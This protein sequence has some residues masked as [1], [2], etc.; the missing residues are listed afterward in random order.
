MA[1]LITFFC[2]CNPAKNGIFLFNLM[3]LFMNTELFI[4]KEEA[5][6]GLANLV[7]RPDQF[8]SKTGLIESIGQMSQREIFALVRRAMDEKSIRAFDSAKKP[9]MGLKPAEDPM[10][11]AVGSQLAQIAGELKR[12]FS[13]QIAERKNVN[14]IKGAA[15]EKGKVLFSDGTV[16]SEKELAKDPFAR[17]LAGNEMHLRLIDED[18]ANLAI[19]EVM[20]LMR[21]DIHAAIYREFDADDEEDT[22]VHHDAAVVYAF[23][24][25]NAQSKNL[26]RA[27]RE[28]HYEE[29]RLDMMQDS[30][31]SKRLVVRA[32]PFMTGKSGFPLAMMAEFD[33]RNRA[34]MLYFSAEEKEAIKPRPVRPVGGGERTQYGPDP[35]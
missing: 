27:F 17:A 11:L 1:G 34:H 15:V 14:R 9:G 19:R 6:P 20:A 8:H 3:T 29:A 4:N 35:C 33:S 7:T 10:V 23:T 18:P 21:E 32:N 25:P 30:Q 28:N 13:T 16:M 31:M 5:L 12:G 22:P 26:G 2:F 24:H